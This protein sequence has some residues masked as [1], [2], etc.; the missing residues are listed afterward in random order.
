VELESALRD[1]IC[2]RALTFMAAANGDQNQLRSS[3]PNLRSLPAIGAGTST[4]VT[5]VNWLWLNI[6][7]MA[8]FF[9]AVAGVPLWLVLRRPD[10]GPQAADQEDA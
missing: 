1:H 3:P 10:L 7:L 5:Q 2:G 8:L 9:V 6:P 4:E